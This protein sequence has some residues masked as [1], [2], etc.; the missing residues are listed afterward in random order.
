[1]YI[2]LMNNQMLIISHRYNNDANSLITDQLEGGKSVISYALPDWL[3]GSYSKDFLLFCVF[4]SHWV[5]YHNIPW[6]QYTTSSV[7]QWWTKIQNIYLFGHYLKSKL[8]HVIDC[9]DLA[10]CVSTRWLYEIGFG[11][12]WASFCTIL[13]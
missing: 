4:K 6:L 13:I 5:Y 11:M 10:F 9:D 2:V 7:N 12:M 3:K 8:C 1:M